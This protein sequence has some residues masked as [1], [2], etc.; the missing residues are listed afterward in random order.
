VGAIVE[1]VYLFDLA[2]AQARWL[3]VRQAAVAQNVANA[4][5]PGYKGLEVAPFSDVFDSAGLQMTVTQPDHLTPNSFELASYVE[6]D[7]TPWEVT[8]SGNSVSLEQ[9]MLNANEV[10]RDYSLNM[11]TMK[12]F[13]QMMSMS[14]KP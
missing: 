14:L 12:A 11:A 3:S 6:K 10:N 5:T 7:S 4:N 2:A 8:Y 9:E 1:P 13:N